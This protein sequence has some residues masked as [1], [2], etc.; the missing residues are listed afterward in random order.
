MS[1][2]TRRHFL[3]TTGAGAALGLGLRAA[4]GVREPEV[5]AQVPG[6]RPPKMP[7]GVAVINPRDRVPVSLIIDDST[8]L[9]NLAHFAIPQFHE[10][11]PDQYFQP[12]KTLPREIPDAFVRRFGEWCAA[13]GI[14]GKYSVIPY[15]A[16]VGWLDRDLPG[17]SKQELNASL[18][19]VRSLM[20]PNWD[21]HP[22]MVSHTWAIDTTTGRP[23]PERTAGFMENWGFSVGKSAD[24]LGEYL[25]FAL[26]ILKNVGLSCEGITTPGGFGNR[27]LAELS[28]GVLHACRD[29]FRAEVPHYFRHLFTDERSVAPRVEYASGLDGPD[30]KC[31]V[32][33][34]GCTGDWFGGWDGLEPGSVD[35]FITADHKAGR[36][37]EVI[38]RG[39]PAILVC[40][41]PGMYFNGQEVGFKIFQEVV[42]RLDD[43]YD[44]L[45]WMKLSQIARYWAARELTRIERPGP[46]RV[47]FQA[48]FACPEFTI[49]LTLA[50][51][52]GLQRTNRVRISTE[53]KETPLTP[54]AALRQLKPGTFHRHD[55]T[56]V[57]CFDLSKG[58]SGLL[59]E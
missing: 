33:M 40:H 30:P 4:P 28:Q 44:H 41:W 48:P 55:R 38:A 29:V 20:M 25:S 17:W 23:F 50:E 6:E 22:E 24:Q 11:F 16:C 53:S 59:L 32:S 18:E 52:F 47:E 15:P 45:A 42:R 12:W 3:R 5:L 36:L 27:A 56:L 37:P 26:T 34:I 46:G 31:V 39:E 19:L 2:P 7:A 58:P 1:Q 9:V 14:K 10:V 13:R 43:A 35:Q 54:V 57:A 49:K 21:I 51:D 8:C